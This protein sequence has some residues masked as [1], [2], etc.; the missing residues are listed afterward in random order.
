MN[1]DYFSHLT[2]EERHIIKDKG[3]EIPFTGEYNDFFQAG[4]FFSL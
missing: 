2:P 4:I 3:T 1:N